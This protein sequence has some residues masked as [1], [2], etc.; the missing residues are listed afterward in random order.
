MRYTLSLLFISFAFIGRSQTLLGGM[1]LPNND[2]YAIEKVGNTVYIGGFFS[3]VDGLPRAGLAR[4]DAT[5]GTLDAWGPTG[6]TNGVTSINRVAD[7]LVVGGSFQTVNGQSRQGICL[8]DLPSGNLNSW[9]GDANYISWRLGVGVDNNIFYYPALSPS[10]IVAVDATTGLATGWQSAPD[11][12]GGG[13]NINA[14]HV[15]DDH[16]YV[17]GQFHFSTGP[18]VYSDLCRFDKVTGAL[19]STWHPDPAVNNFGV[20]SI[21]RTNDHLFVGGDFDQINGVARQGV[22]AYD[23]NGNLAPFDQNSSSSEVLSLYPDGDYIWVGGN[24][25]QLGGQT[26]YRIAQIR[27][28]NAQA[29]CWNAASTSSAWSTVQAILVASDTV[30]AGPFGGADLNTFV[31]SPLPQSTM[32]IAGPDT[33]APGQIAVYSVPQLAGH[34]YAWTVTGGTGTSTTN[35]INVNWGSGP[36]GSVSVSVNN[37]NASNC[38][39][40][41]T[42]AI[43]I[44]GSN[45]VGSDRPAAQEAFSLFP[46][47]AGDRT[48]L[49]FPLVG[50][51][52]KPVVHMVDMLGNEVRSFVLQH[53]RTTLDLTDLKQGIYFVRVTTEQGVHAKRLIVS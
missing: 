33:V 23:L 45:S 53:D 19:D 27:I 17:G 30:Y 35:S 21:V 12:M 2:V 47:P 41:V 5:S 1:P 4:F 34:T 9:S 36:A 28:S 24:S 42:Q 25:S 46:N 52:K 22:A 40:L 14:V 51:T 20:T 16:V 15:G 26:R 37:T 39:G 10:R 38:S 31:G 7:K 29:T 50:G 11:F 6:I 3:T 8:F 32:P 44:T 18:S 13:P 43:V 49:H 48:V